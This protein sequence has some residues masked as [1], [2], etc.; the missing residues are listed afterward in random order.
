MDQ[1]G[2]SLQKVVQDNFHRLNM[3]GMAETP[4]VTCNC[5]LFK[6]PHL[7]TKHTS[8]RSRIHHDGQI[9]SQP[10]IGVPTDGFLS[11]YA[12]IPSTS[13]IQTTPVNDVTTTPIDPTD[14]S[15]TSVT[16]SIPLPTVESIPNEMYETP[17]PPDRV[18]TKTTVSNGLPE[19]IE[20]PVIEG[21]APFRYEGSYAQ[22]S[23]QD[24]PSY[25]R[26]MGRPNES[27]KFQYIQGVV[28]MY[29]AS[30]S[31]GLL[32]VVIVTIIYWLLFVGL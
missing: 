27:C 26:E 5:S 18:T 14:I 1:I 11:Q 13:V 23:R 20:E 2:N 12:A 19:E 3:L 31:S 15:T 4:E 8:T 6:P 30:V 32:Y 21:F 10:P 29:L 16:D 7:V 17:P 25:R 24:V 22:V 9:Q 28:D